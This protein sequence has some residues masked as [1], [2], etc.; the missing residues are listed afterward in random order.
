MDFLWAENKCALLF[1]CDQGVFK[2]QNSV[3]SSFHSN[4]LEFMVSKFP[5]LKRAIELYL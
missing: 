4:V 3:C 5:I 1:G 2:V